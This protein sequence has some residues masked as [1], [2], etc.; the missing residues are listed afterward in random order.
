MVEPAQRVALADEQHELVVALRGRERPSPFCLRRVVS[1]QH[2]KRLE[3]NLVAVVLGD[4]HLPERAAA[5]ALTHS[6]VLKR[7]MVR[8]RSR[9]LSARTLHRGERPLSTTLPARRPSTPPLWRPGAA[10][11]VPRHTERES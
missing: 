4:P 5:N 3:R 9:L 1:A 2:V 6:D 8:Q 7:D 11:L 10:E